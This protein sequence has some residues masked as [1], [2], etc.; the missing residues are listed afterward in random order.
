[1]IRKDKAGNYLVKT[2]A[3]YLAAMDHQRKELRSETYARKA[4]ELD[5]KRKNVRADDAA[6]AIHKGNQ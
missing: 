2:H 4:W 3:E 6:W 1:M 5:C